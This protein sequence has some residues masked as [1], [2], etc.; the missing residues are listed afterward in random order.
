MSLQVLPLAV[1]MVVGPGLMAAVILVTTRR[2]V[3]AGVAYVLGF[4]T[5]ATVGTA[6]AWGLA[7]LLGDGVSLGKPED[8]GST[9][10]IIQLVL[11]ALLVAA[12]VKA[13]LGRAT[14][15]PPKWLSRVME[16]DPRSALKM[17]LLIVPLMPTD[18]IVMLTVGVNL[19]QHDSTLLDAIPFLVLTALI[20]ALPLLVYLVFRR[21][22]EREMPPVRDWMNANSWFVNVV[23]YVIFILLILL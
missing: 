20:V 23:V 1:T 14:A 17:G 6:L 18:D 19:A 15:E 9:G 3:A 2:P 8:R 10:T 16:A 22:A 7:E 4:M 12:S 5:S 11:V 21:W 13:Y